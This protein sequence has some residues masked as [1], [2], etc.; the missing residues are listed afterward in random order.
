MIRVQNHVYLY[1]HGIQECIIHGRIQTQD[2]VLHNV[3]NF[4][5]YMQ[6]ITH[7]HVY[8]NV[9]Q[10][11]QLFHMIHLLM[12][13]H[14]HVY[15]HVRMDLV[16]KNHNKFVY[17]HV[18]VFLQYYFFMQIMQVAYQV[19][20]KDI[21]QILVNNYVLPNVLQIHN[22]LHMIII[23]LVCN[24]VLMVHMLIELQE[25]VKYSVHKKYYNMQIIQQINVLINAQLIHNI[26]VSMILMEIENVYLIVLLDYLLI[27]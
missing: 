23:I 18:Q 17:H 7:K 27:H 9:L 4:L 2:N 11:V 1:V 24:N 15:V 20:H 19:V 3:H 13:Y 10:L 5:F 12:I 16:G 25:N 22:T 14:K 8:L 26:M 21:M 6:I